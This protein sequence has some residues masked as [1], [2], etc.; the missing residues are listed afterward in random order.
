MARFGEFKAQFFSRSNLNT[1]LADTN[2]VNYRVPISGDTLFR[3]ETSAPARP[4]MP[5]P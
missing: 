5:A 3:G 2:G 1:P 4:A